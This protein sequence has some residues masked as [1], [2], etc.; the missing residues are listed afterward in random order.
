MGCQE[1]ASTSEL[2]RHWEEGLVAGENAAASVKA[3]RRLRAE[4]QTLT[5]IPEQSE[6]QACC[7]Q[8]EE[9]SMMQAQAR[10]CIDLGELYAHSI[11]CY[12]LA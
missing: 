5:S 7:Q 4:G 12:C 10:A 11:H 8:Q 3:W 1:S 9:A 2:G 6:T